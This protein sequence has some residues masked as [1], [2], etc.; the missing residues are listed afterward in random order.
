MNTVWDDEGAVCFSI[1]L[2]LCARPN[3]TLISC[4]VRN[5]AYAATEFFLG[6][7]KW[8]KLSDNICSIS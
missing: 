5:V 7:R 4:K 1:C 8:L 2:L 6:F 3:P